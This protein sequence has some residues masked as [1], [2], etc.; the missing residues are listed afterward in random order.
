MQQVLGQRGDLPHRL[1]RMHIRRDQRRQPIAQGDHRVAVGSLAK[2]VL[3]GLGRAGHGIDQSQGGLR[4]PALGHAAHHGALA[5]GVARQELL[6]GE[7]DHLIQGRI[8]LGH[9]GPSPGP[10]RDP[11]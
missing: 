4:R 9:V 6:H 5:L 7:L 1:H 3:D 2:G 11:Q 8:A 10:R